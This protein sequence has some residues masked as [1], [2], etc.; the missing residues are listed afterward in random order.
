MKESDGR[1]MIMV[2][3]EHKGLMMM[4]TLFATLPIK[5]GHL[6]LSKHMEDH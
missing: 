2:M 3:R 1:V 6:L 5:D 4:M